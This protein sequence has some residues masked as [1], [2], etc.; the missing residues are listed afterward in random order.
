MGELIEQF[1]SRYDFVEYYLFP[2]P[3]GVLFFDSQGKATLM[4]VATA[5]SLGAQF[6]IARDQGAP[7]EMLAALKEL[8]IVPFFSDSGGTCPASIGE[9]WLQYCL[10]ANI[11]RGRQDYYWAC[12]DLPP[13][14]LPSPV[15][16]YAD[17]LQEQASAST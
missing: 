11:C 8:R 7:A 15:F 12:F 3:E 2:N 13:E 16:P 4:V 1:F 9:E 14:Y 17:F 10:P 6:E 5:S